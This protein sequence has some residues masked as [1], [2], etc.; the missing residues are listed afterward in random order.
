MLSIYFYHAGKKGI[1][2]LDSPL[3]CYKT[4]VDTEELVLPDNSYIPHVSIQYR[5]G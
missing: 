4:L 3:V 1:V 5:E 2:L